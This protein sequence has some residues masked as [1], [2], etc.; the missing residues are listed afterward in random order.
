ML[1]MHELDLKEVLGVI[2][3]M[4]MGFG[5]GGSSHGQYFMPDMIR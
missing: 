4:G 1:A 5:L 2:C 3:A